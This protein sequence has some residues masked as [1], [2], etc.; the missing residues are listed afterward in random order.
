VK[1][2]LGSGG[3][4]LSVIGGTAWRGFKDRKGFC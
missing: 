4:S 1:E 2:R 3:L